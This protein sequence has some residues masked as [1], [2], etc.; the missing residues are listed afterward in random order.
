MSTKEQLVKL[1]ISEL[2]QI[3][4]WIRGAFAKTNPDAAP[5]SSD[6]VISA[7]NAACESSLAKDAAWLAAHPEVP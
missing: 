2:P 7:F 6:E 1:A 4:G 3:V 5:P